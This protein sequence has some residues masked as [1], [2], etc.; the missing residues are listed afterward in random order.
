MC[1]FWLLPVNASILVVWIRNL[2]V[3]WLA[4]FSSDHNVVRVA[5]YLLWVEA[6]HTGS[7]LP[8]LKSTCAL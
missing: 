3:G 2:S 7:M 1:M 6:V 4:P 5:G 8:P